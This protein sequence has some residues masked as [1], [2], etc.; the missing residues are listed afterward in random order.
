MSETNKDI[1]VAFYKASPA[2]P[3]ATHADDARQ[4]HVGHERRL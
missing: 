4:D 1:A 2:A 3:C